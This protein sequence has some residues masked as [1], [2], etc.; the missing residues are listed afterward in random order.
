MPA[1]LV[2]DDPATEAAA[3]T[4]QQ[5]KA[6]LS[7]PGPVDVPQWEAPDYGGFDFSMLLQQPQSQQGYQPIKMGLQDIRSLPFHK[8]PPEPQ[9][10]NTFS[11]DQLLGKPGGK[12]TG[13]MGPGAYGWNG[14]TGGSGTKG[15]GKYGLQAQFWQA[16]QSANAAMQAAGLGGFGITDGWRSYDAQV[17]LKKKKPT[18]AATPGRSVHGLGL[19]SDLKLS[20]AQYNWLKQN[21]SKF[22]IINLPGETWHW[23]LSPSLWKGWS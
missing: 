20:T 22:G 6:R 5:N 16:L 2:G 17:A 10:G 12:S 3:R 13:G 23:Q 8:A 9:S 4:Y 7:T 11:L 19:A 21:G 15:T 1:I 14:S 18:L